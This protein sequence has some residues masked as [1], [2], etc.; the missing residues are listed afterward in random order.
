MHEMQSR[1]APRVTAA[2]A[3][4]AAV[5]D[6]V[7]EEYRAL[8]VALPGAN[9]RT[10]WQESHGA[11]RILAHPALTRVSEEVG[12]LLAYACDAVV[13]A[14]RIAAAVKDAGAAIVEYMDYLAASRPDRPMRLLPAYRALLQSRGVEDVSASDLFYPDL[15]SELPARPAPVPFGTEALRAERRRFEAAFLRWLRNA[16]DAGALDD[17]RAAVAA[18][19]A[20][21]DTTNARGAWCAALAAL[22]ALS[23]GT[24]KPDP[25]LRRFVSQ[26]HIQIG[27]AIDGSNEF[28]EALFRQA[29]YFVAL[30]PAVGISPS[31]LADEM[32][33][34][35]AL[36]G[37]LDASDAGAPTIAVIPESMAKELKRLNEAWAGWDAGQTQTDALRGEIDAVQRAASLLSGPPLELLTQICSAMRAQ[38]VEGE[39]HPVAAVEISCALLMVEDL[40]ENAPRAAASFARRAANARARLQ[41]CQ[42]DAAALQRL[43]PMELLDVQARRDEVEVVLSHTLAQADAAIRHAVSV[44]E[45]F[46]ADAGTRGTLAG[47]DKPLAQCIGM[48]NMLQDEPAAAAI[49]LC[50]EEIARLAAGPDNDGAIKD[51]LA[52]RLTAL[53]DYVRAPRQGHASL[54]ALLARAGL[55]APA[56]MRTAPTPAKTAVQET[57]A[58]TIDSGEALDKDMLDVFLEEAVEV[59]A[60]IAT[61]LPASQQDPNNTEH[62]TALRRAFHTLKGSG[63][64]VGLTQL[65]EAAWEVEQVFNK[66]TQDRLPGTPDVY[67]L[68]SLA[69]ENFTRWVA[70]LRAG[71]RGVVDATMLADWARRVR[72]GEAL[73]SAPD[74]PTSDAAPETLTATQKIVVKIGATTLSPALYAIFIKE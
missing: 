36:D 51:R 63:R 48:F 23:S 6:G 58:L 54:D 59:L 8:V 14:A 17:M 47:L 24:L 68:I 41:A 65:G 31:G 56:A 67:R 37:M 40:I 27:H 29:L 49:G 64:M 33:R 30:A 57:T 50:R 45:G 18:V 3:A 4:I 1:A 60:G 55:G 25:E 22:E 32:R 53:A 43:P 11:V 5:R 62:L 26:L 9:A 69:H 46:F 28:P 7:A 16:G 70:E 42:G 44:L 2:I 15:H 12:N 39:P 71:R 52:R 10:H 21:R 72:A 13:D 38:A 66:L 20:S 74:A 73:P 19:E 35:Y 61:A 34:A